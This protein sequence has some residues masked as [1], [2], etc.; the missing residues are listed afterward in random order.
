MPSALARTNAKGV[1]VVSILVGSAIGTLALG[2]FKSWS[3]LV[4][5]VTGATAI[6]YA[7]APVSLA[8]LH[9][10]DGG[11]PRSYRMPMPRVLL[12]A[13]FCSANLII[14]WGGFET[15]WKLALAMLLGLVLFAIGAMRARTG[16]QRTIRNAFWVAPWLG[17]HVLLGAVGRYGPGARNL[18]PGWVDLAVVIVFALAIFYWAVSVTVTKEDAAAAVAKDARQIDYAP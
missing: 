10:V 11:R 2:P 16:A 18:L 8:A 7:F 1:P 13:G 5:V 9:R 14:Y 17:G 6:M 4:N 3:A 12:P 15:T